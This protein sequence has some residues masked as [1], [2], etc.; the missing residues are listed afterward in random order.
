VGSPSH[1]LSVGSIK[2]AS[3]SSKARAAIALCLFACLF[4]SLPTLAQGNTAAVTAADFATASNGLYRIAGTVINAIT[5]E[6]VPR[7]AVAIPNLSQSQIVQTALSDG[8]GH[9]SL[10]RLPA[11]KYQLTASKRGFRTAFFDQHEDYNSAIVTGPDQ[12][13]DKL[14]FRL[15]PDATLHGIITA[16][17]GDPV[18]SAIVMLFRKP[19][20]NHLTEP[21]TPAGNAITDDTGA[22]EFS[23]LAPGEYLLAVKATPWY[24][25]HPL[26]SHSPQPSR[27]S[28][29]PSPLDVA[30]PITFFSG[31]TEEASATPI[32]LASGSREEANLSLNAVPALHLTVP[33]PAE[34]AP[35]ADRNSIPQIPRTVL[36]QSVF[37]TEI[38]TDE[39]NS[40]NYPLGASR[41]GAAEFNGVAPGHYQLEEGNPPHTMELNAS[42]SQQIDTAQATPSLQ[43]SVEVRSNSGTPVP[44][45]RAMTLESLDFE[46]RFIPLQSP[47]RPGGV[48]TGAVP[49]GKWK[50]WAVS[51]NNSLTVLSITEDGKVQPGN[52][53]TLLDRPLSLG[54]TVTR[55]ATRVEGFARKDD[56]GVAGAMIVLFPRNLEADRSLIRRDQTDS[57]G[58]FAL[59]DAAPG[60]Y[61]VV[62]IENGWDLDWARPEVMARYLSHGIPVTIKGSS[63]KL[64]RLSQPVPVQPVATNP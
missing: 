50:I 14:S 36:H 27:Q 11:A 39:V 34:I 12:E 51:E 60:D 26:S 57:D 53:F 45:M 46:H 6:P 17:T 9:F 61:L 55:T 37:G 35:G 64:I 2:L 24:A 43:V 7:A 28:G 40:V 42:S 16:D 19:A 31:T 56:K 62:A 38:A 15:L 23:D 59:L 25:V 41:P 21:I 32:F 54:V 10:D 8:N 58:S 22:Y 4:S 33:L 13:T 18:E 52:Q 1:S 3:L 44:E 20:R 30:Y 5:G 63:G 49:P 29:T 48:F 47:A